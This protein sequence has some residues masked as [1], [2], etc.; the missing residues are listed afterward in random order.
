[1]KNQK[2]IK[3]KSPKSAYNGTPKVKKK[4]IKSKT[5]TAHGLR[6]LFVD[7][8]KDIYW[9]EKALTKAFPKMIKNA[10][11]EEL[12]DALAEHLEVTKG[13]VTRLEEVFFIVGEKA[14]AK[15]CESMVG[16]IKEAE[17][18]M[19]TTEKGVVRDAGIILAG[20]K[21]EHYEI[22]TYG[23]LC[24]FAKTLEEDE[25]SALLEE[26]LNEEKNADEKL[27]KIANSSN[28]NIENTH[29]NSI[30]VLNNLLEINNDRIEGYN[31]ASK[32]T[33]EP[34]L[35]KL[36]TTLEKTSYKCKEE[37]TA[38]VKRLGGTPVEGTRTTG[39]L[40]RAWMDVKAA[41]TNKERKGILKSCEFGEG[42]AVKNYADALQN[43]NISGNLYKM[44]N[45]QYALIKADHDKIQA[46]GDGTPFTK[47][48]AKNSIQKQTGENEVK[49][50]SDVIEGIRDLF[51]GAL[52]DAYWAEK[53]LVK[54]MPKMIKN[55]T[56]VELVYA[57]TEH[58]EETKEQVTRLEE[59]FS[60]IE[61]KAVAKQCEAM[62]GL[63]KEAEEIM[64]ATERGV[65]RDAGIV[66]AAQK[67]EHYE[68]A[69]YGTLCSLAKTLEE[70]DAAD[71]LEETLNEEKGADERLTEI[72]ESSINFQAAENDDYYNDTLVAVKTKRK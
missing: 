17:E 46:L 36:F 47:K 28:K 27:S 56:S 3:S 15:K 8:L 12:V 71:L 18:I 52:K 29:D 68:I 69:T 1:M 23:T 59:V 5:D 45:K 30:D 42:V 55:A 40:Y 57:L 22:A 35:K 10:T 11:S 70:Y 63:I 37:L 41:L 72:A 4:E 38:E 66:L 14:V 16:L 65:V 34:D 13:H 33:N 49:Q 6:E 21:V 9:A 48:T 58:H 53:A 31:H 7:E 20:Q 64:E 19:K 61:E 51:I 24:A 50:K 60:K 26:T 44:I 2:N 32:E 54:A 39:K 62:I 43:D 25:A 67:V